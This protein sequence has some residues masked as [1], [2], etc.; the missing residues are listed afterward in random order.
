MTVPEQPERAPESTAERWDPVPVPPPSGQARAAALERF[1]ALATPAGALGRLQDLGAWLAA[2]QGSCPPQP[3]ERVRAVV[4]AGDHGVVR[5]GVSAY[6]AAVT[7]AMVRALVDGVAG[8][9]ALAAQHGVPVR[10]LDISVDDDL[11]GLPGEVR[12][13]KLGRSC[14]A[15]DVEDAMSL[16]AT[17]EALA[18]GERVAAEEVAAGAQ[19]L[20]VGDLGIGNTTPAAALVAHLLDL[21]AAEVTGPGSGLDEAGRARKAAVVQQAV[22]RA[23]GTTDPLARLAA[24][25]SPDLAVAVGIQLGAARAGVPVLLDG[26][27]S[28]AE[29][30]VAES[31]APGARAWFAAGHRSPEPAHAHALAVLDLEPV[32]DLGMR[33]GEGSGA[34][35]ALPLLRS[36][37][38]L[39]REVALLEDLLPS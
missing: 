27:I 34:L 7:P 29:A 8:V 12:A 36:A 37:V 18:V 9:S 13:H 1:A 39:L 21:P 24:L 19:L 6:P 25:G 28:A 23:A 5:S 10:V 26:A 15:I 30:L 14:G 33:L 22:D 38:Q 32:L 31:L 20:V 35:A 2:C 3:L 4:P 11:A 16:A 17:R